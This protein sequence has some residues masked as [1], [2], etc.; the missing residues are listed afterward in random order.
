MRNLH[1]DVDRRDKPGDD[2]EGRMKPRPPV[3]K[4]EVMTTAAA[5]PV[6]A[7]AIEDDCDALMA[8]EMTP[9]GPWRLEGHTMTEPD[10]A[11]IRAQLALAA[12]GIG[13]APPE[14]KIERLPDVDWLARNRRAFPPLHAG[15]YF[16]Y[17]SHYDGLM[18]PG[19]IGLTLDAGMAFGSGEHATTRGCL[20][21]IDRRARLRP[22]PRRMLDHGCGSGILGIA[23]AKTWPRCTVA[24]ADIDRDSVRIAAENALHNGVSRRRLRVRWSDGV[25]R[26]I[27]R[28]RYDL[29]CANILAR[30]LRRL[31]RPLAQSVR[32]GGTLVLS[33][34]LAAQGADIVAAYRFQRLAFVRRFTLDGWL[35]LSFRRRRA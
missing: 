24:A 20:L 6:L 18:P 31:S 13:L 23:A 11:A 4:I 1:A 30:P 35:A 9:G 26:P 8:F 32:A 5:Q 25:S 21:A 17:G 33:G 10:P 28:R 14:A 12:A 3:W 34:L 16:V 7:K 27:R 2:E 29:V 22:G 19:M 15:R